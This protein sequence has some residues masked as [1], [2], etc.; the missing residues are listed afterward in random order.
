M[1]NQQRQL[2]ATIRNFFMVATVE[3]MRRALPTYTDPFS[4]DCIQE[5]IDEADCP[6]CDSFGCCS[7]NLDHTRNKNCLVK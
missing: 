1:T 4:R 7:P 6:V 2:R 5:L 3:E